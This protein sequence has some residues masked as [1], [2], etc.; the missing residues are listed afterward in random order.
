MIWPECCCATFAVI[1][2]GS[3]RSPGLL[4]QRKARGFITEHLRPPS[5]RQTP[6]APHRS[7]AFPPIAQNAMDRTPGF[8]VE[9]MPLRLKSYGLGVTGLGLGRSY[10][11]TK[12]L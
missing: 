2:I 8:I 3:Q 11:G 6:L 4:R 1:W 5:V 9:T 7:C 12:G 10:D